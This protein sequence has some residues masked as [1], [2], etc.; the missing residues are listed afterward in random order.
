MSLPKGFRFNQANLQNFVDC[1]RRF[2]LLHLLRQKWPAIESEPN[3]QIEKDLL[4]GQSFHKIIYQ[5]FIGLSIAEINKSIYDNDLKIWWDNFLSTFVQTSIC[6]N[7]KSIYPE[8]TVIVQLANFDL[9]AKYDLLVINDDGSAIIYDWKTSTKLPSR[10]WLRDRLQSKVYLW[11]FYDY[12]IRME[13]FPVIVPDQIELNYWFANYP[14]TPIK[15]NY[16]L[17]RAI[18]DEEYLSNTIQMIEG[19]RNDEFFKTSDEHRCQFCLYRSLCDRE[20]NAGIITELANSLDGEEELN[21][22][23]LDFDD[24]TEMRY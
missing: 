13:N 18:A 4:L 1:R 10:T 9:I 14:E 3:I 2:Q 19:I 20:I 23:D 6:E 7:W 11:A 12:A 22:F 8:F 17:S 24:I 21:L 15:F 5:Y 16:N